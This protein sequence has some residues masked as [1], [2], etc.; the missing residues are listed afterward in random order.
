M[1]ST[2]HITSM[3]PTGIPYTYIVMPSPESQAPP[4]RLFQVDT[5]NVLA[6]SASI[7]PDDVAVLRLDPPPRTDDNEDTANAD[8]EEPMAGDTEAE[9]EDDAEEEVDTNGSGDEHD[10]EW[11]EGNVR[12]VGHNFFGLVSALP[13]CLTNLFVLHRGLGYK[14]RCSSKCDG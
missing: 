1:A 13:E 7:H 14:I 8:A 4:C 3:S 11:E 6:P 5:T 12:L 10:R 2:V 9:T